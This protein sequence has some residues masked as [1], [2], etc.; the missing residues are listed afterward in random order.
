MNET[1]RWSDTQDTPGPIGNTSD[2]GTGHTRRSAPRSFRTAHAA[3]YCQVT[4]R[5]RRSFC[6]ISAGTRANAS[7]GPRSPCAPIGRRAL[8]EPPSF[9]PASSNNTPTAVGQ[10]PHPTGRA[11]S[12][13]GIEARPPAEGPQ[14]PVDPLT[15]SVRRVFIRQHRTQS[16]TRKTPLTGGN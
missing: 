10:R 15:L 6:T 1:C 4:P 13:V 2:H 8:S 5:T 14:S 7:D 9:V 11:A 3:G 12:S 16:V